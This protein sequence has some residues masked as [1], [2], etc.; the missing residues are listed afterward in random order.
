M[1]IRK[2]TSMTMLVSFILEGI[3]SII[4]FIV[5]HGRVAYWA[6]WHLWGM[7]KT[8]WGNLH[9]NLGF[10]FLLAGMMHIYYNWAPMKAYMKNRARELKVFTP[11]FNVALLLTL[12]VGVGTYLEIPPMSS[13]IQMG[14]AIKDNSAKKFGEPPYGHA[15]LSSLQLFCKKQGLD[16]DQA[17]GLLQKAGIQLNDSKDTLATVSAANKLSPQEIYEIIKPAAVVNA[18]EGKVSFPDT[19]MQGFGNKTLAGICAEYNLM[20]HDIKRGLA[21]KGVNAEAEMTIKEIAAAS[22]IDAMAL[23]E[24]LHSVVYEN[25]DN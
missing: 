21:G 25:P 9:I 17:L 8:E 1:N 2:I 7:T 14:D 13:V 12:A 22:E 10:L 19:P 23:F 3:T 11:S 18:V 16:P 5:P 24:L 6:D 4:L 20:L 15:E